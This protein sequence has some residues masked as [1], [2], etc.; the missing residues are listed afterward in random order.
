M[1][2]DFHLS[3]GQ[4]AIQNGAA[5]TP[6]FECPWWICVRRDDRFGFF[7]VL[8]LRIPA[9][10]RRPL[11]RS[12]LARRRAFSG[13]CSQFENDALVVGDVCGGFFKGPRNIRLFLVECGTR[14]AGAPDIGRRR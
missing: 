3:D 4:D 11:A 10:T 2:S 13:A 14:N 7:F 12:P 6:T 9:T 1:A 5:T 8:L